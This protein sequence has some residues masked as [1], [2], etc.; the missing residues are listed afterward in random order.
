MF[1]HE[2][3][4]R[5]AI[6]IRALVHAYADGT[7][8]LR[9]VDLCIGAGEAVAIVGANGAGKSTL[10]KHLNGL[11]LAGSGS[12]HID[13]IALSRAS[14]NDVRRRVGYVFQDADDQLFM[15][16][17]QDDVAF[18]PLNLGLAAGEAQSRVAAALEAVGAAHLAPR[19]PYRLSGGEKR[20]V[21]I[22][23]VLAMAPSILVL[24]EPSTGLDPAGR[25]R[26]IK[27]LS[28]LPQTRIVA[29]HD[30]SLVLQLCPRA[31]VLHQGRV[32]ADG[33]PANLFAD[34][35]LLRRCQL[36]SPCEGLPTWQAPAEG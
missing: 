24:D 36:E 21:A 26:L 25:R 2:Q 3:V 28:R 10:L 4:N 29:T 5:P 33:A 15:P 23:G 16:T 32:V 7:Q 9:G 31:L 18:G 12:V 20:A 22:A 27:L 13:G 19:A 17:V 11:L 34:A 8:A 1:G 30:L 14:L 35:A 6:D